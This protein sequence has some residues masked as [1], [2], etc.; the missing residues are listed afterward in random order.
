M[1]TVSDRLP[2]LLTQ[3]LASKFAGIALA[4]IRREWPHSYQH[5]AR[6]PADVRSPR[7]LHP[8]FFG[9]FDWHSAVHGHWTLAR[10]LRLF[11]TLPSAAH[12]RAVLDGSLTKDHIAVELAYFQAPGRGAFERPYGWGWLLALAAELRAGRDPC[13]RRW[14][15]AIR[16]LEKFIAESFC[17]YLPRLPYPVRTGVHSNTAFALTLA[18]DYAREAGH[19][20]LEAVIVKRSRDFYRADAGAP[21]AWEPCGEDFLSPSLSEADLMSRILP[22]SEFRRWLTR[23]LPGLA[24][25]EPFAHMRAP[26]IRDRCDP[27]QVH[28]DGLCLSRA[29]ALRTIASFMSSN[30]RVRAAAKRHARAGLARVS[31]GDYAGEHWL[32]SFA[33]YLLANGSASH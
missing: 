4:G 26:R 23:F 21:I 13:V 20:R 32:A 28:L 19:P 2:R 24:R 29:W 22:A 16:P 10:L 27:K 15:R 1:S 5:L 11:P 3:S 17:D 25:G 14:S 18:L 31:S 6:H 8:A 7:E 30:D 33:V 9:C 12:I